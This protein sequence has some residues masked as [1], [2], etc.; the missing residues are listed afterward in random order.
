MGVCIRF[1]ETALVMFPCAH[2][3]RRSPRVSGLLRRLGMAAGNPAG[4]PVTPLSRRLGAFPNGP[5]P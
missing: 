5:G 2:P 1:Q 3:R 4:P